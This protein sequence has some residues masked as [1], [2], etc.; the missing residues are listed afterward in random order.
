MH[1]TQTAKPIARDA[2]TLEIGQFNS[3][4][5]S[6]DDVFHVALAI[7]ER[8]DLPIRFMRKLAKLPRKFRRHNLVRR[9]AA[10]VQLLYSP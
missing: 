8:A 10:R 3:A 7:D 9:N 6:D 2:H 1:E 5:I 4:R